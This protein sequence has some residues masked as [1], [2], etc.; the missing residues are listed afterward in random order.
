VLDT[1]ADQILSLDHLYQNGTPRKNYAD[2]LIK[3]VLSADMSAVF[4]AVADTIV[5]TIL[6]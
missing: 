1:E 5:D 2:I 6:M 3:L 4:S